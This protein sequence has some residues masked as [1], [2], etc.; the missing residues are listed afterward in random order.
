[1]NIIETVSNR[2]SQEQKLLAFVTKHCPNL[3]KGSSFISGETDL[4]VSV[5]CYDHSRID[6]LSEW[7]ETFGLDDWMAEQ[8]SNSRDELKWTRTLDGVN[9]I[10]YNAKEL[11]PTPPRPVVKSDWPLQLGDGVSLS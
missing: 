9:L 7:S 1:M 4:Y 5:R 2:I 6:V 3:K 10:I 8:D 11:P